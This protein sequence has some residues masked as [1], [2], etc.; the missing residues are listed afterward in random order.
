MIFAI[1]VIIASSILA[2]MFIHFAPGDPVRLM[3]G[4]NYDPEIADRIS[5]ELG[6]DKPF[7]HPVFCLGREDPEGDLGQ[8]FLLR[9]SVSE[10]LW[11]DFRPP[12]SWQWPPSASGSS[13]GSQPGHLRTRR[14]TFF[15]TV[16]RIVAMLGISMPVFWIGSCF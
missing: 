13:S 12:P 11:K 9:S 10:L 4:V 5:R 6:L 7:F 15:D 2:F 16:S 1:P 8:S 14:N 3:L